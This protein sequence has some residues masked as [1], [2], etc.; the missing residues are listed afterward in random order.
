MARLYDAQEGTVEVNGVD[1]RGVRLESLRANVCYLMQESIL[2]DRALKENLLLGCPDATDEEVRDALEIAEVN[3]LLCRLPNG[4]DTRLGPRGAKLSGGER[5]RV[6]LART[7]LQKPAVLVLDEATSALDAPSERRILRKLSECLRHQTVVFISHRISSL[8]WVDRILVM[9]K[10]AIA[11]Q[12]SHAD[13][14]RRG[15]LYA[16]LVSRKV[17]T[18]DGRASSE[19]APTQDNLPVL[20][21]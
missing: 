18:G 12:G 16:T 15:G 20:P 10:G 7:L 1:V 13:L 14:I 9:H 8:S 2:F 19:P 3:D 5:Q 6:I 17:A 21:D 11:E 4:L